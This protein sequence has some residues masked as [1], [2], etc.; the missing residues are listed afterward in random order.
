MK[1]QCHFSSKI[2]GF[3]YQRY[4]IKDGEISNLGYSKFYEIHFNILKL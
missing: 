1:I 3:F 4:C 2:V